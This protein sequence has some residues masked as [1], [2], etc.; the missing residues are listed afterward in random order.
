MIDINYFY[1]KLLHATG[2]PIKHFGVKNI[3]RKNKI[4]GLYGIERS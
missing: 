1:K 3:I 4:S 2:V